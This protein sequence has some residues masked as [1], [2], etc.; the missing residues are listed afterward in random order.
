MHK[1]SP[2]NDAMQYTVAVHFLRLL[3]DYCDAN[4]L[5]ASQLLE[6]HGLPVELLEQPEKRIPYL[7]YASMLDSA[8]AQ[9]RDPHLGLH[10]GQFVRP[11]HVGVGALAQFACANVEQQV[12]RLVRYSGLDYDAFRDEVVHE[13]GDVVLRWHCLLPPE[14]ALS[15]HHAELNFA[16]VKTLAP[17]F[18]GSDIRATWIRFRHP[19]PE[20]SEELQRFF[21]CPVYFDAD[22]DSLAFPEAALDLPIQMANVQA[23]A[24]LDNIC[25]QQLKQLSRA[26]P[27]QWLKDCKRSIAEQL[28]NGTPDLSHIAQ[29]L[30]VSPR[31]LRRLLAEQELSFRQLIDELRQTLAE[32]YMADS[33][34]S[35]ADV[36]ALL[37]FSEQSAFQRAYRRWTGESPGKS[38]RSA[39]SE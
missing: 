35:L 9:L 34:L 26:Q 18:T 19:A 6:S 5:P 10:M 12:Q 36:A 30:E 27:P 4:G 25:E 33:E 39:R 7:C 2:D 16:V 13:N 32:Q 31:K 24:M 22:V 3:T 23:L 21:G 14:I 38:R 20:D 1:A 11:G 28:H 15:H 8:A 17:Q 37:G 29:K